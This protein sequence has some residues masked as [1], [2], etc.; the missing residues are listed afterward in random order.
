MVLKIVDA[1]DKTP[2]AAR[3]HL[4]NPKGSPRK[5]PAVPYW[6][7]H[8][9][10]DG[11]IAL[12]LPEGNYTF[13]LERGLEYLDLQG[14]FTIQRSSLDE[15]TLELERFVHMAQEGWWS[16]DLSVH[17]PLKELPLLLRADDLHFAAWFPPADK[18]VS[19]FPPMVQAGVDAASTQNLEYAGEG[20]KLQFHRL[21]T[22][23]LWSE[24]GPELVSSGKLLMDAVSQAHTKVRAAD[25]ASWD[26]PMWVASRRLASVMVLGPLPERKGS[27]DRAWGT[28]PA[29]R[30]LYPPPHGE[31]RW[32]E[33]IYYQLLNCGLQIPPAAG[34]G[35]GL[36]PSC[37]G[38]NRVY[39]YLPSP[40]TPDLWWD[41][42][43]AGRSIVTNGPL[44]IAKVN[45][46]APG[47]VFESPA[48]VAVKLQAELTLHTRETIAYLELV[49]DGQVRHSISL[50]QYKNRNGTL[51]AVEFEQSGWLIVRA[52]TENPEAFHVAMSAPFYVRIGE[53]PTVHREAVTF[54]RDWQ[55]QRI[56]QL[57]KD[58]PSSHP[59]AMKYHQASLEYWTKLLSQ[60]NA[61]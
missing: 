15:R 23:L 8:A 27:L 9:A 37:V 43:D 21:K 13:L 18:P 58:S 44:M 45:G 56:E 61:P 35:S 30:V 55:S 24:H 6:H 42:L 14:G 20:G 60:A 51:P 40:P 54:F 29:D 12:E 33:R 46:Q 7:D 1:K 48:G 31:G 22:P 17:R 5:L 4:I 39:V 3:L 28:R 19:S 34:S 11:Q 47:H 59:D 26:F 16:G 50:E 36:A 38:Q 32:R 41:A 2:I 10:I 25:P 53:F 57:P 49:Q 52:I